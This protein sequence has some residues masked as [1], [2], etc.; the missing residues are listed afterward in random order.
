MTNPSHQPVLETHPMQPT[1]ILKGE[2]R[3]IE[4]VLSCLERIAD[5]CGEDRR[6]DG[7]SA[8]QALEFFQTFAD[9]CHHRK[10]EA[11]LFPA[12][13]AKGFSPRFGPTY[14]MRSEHDEGRR[15]IRA[16]A[17]AVE[18]ASLGDPEAVGQCLEHAR[19]YARLPRA[20]IAK[21]DRCLFPLADEVFS[22]A[23]QEALLA[24][25]DDVEDREMHVGTHE[26]YLRVADELAER[27][28]LSR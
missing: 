16:M 18:D 3:V 8:R 22:A 6:L 11:H 14:M 17:E 21:E 19:G 20:H 27:F 4:Q 5:D 13:E 26:K 24:V 2:H 7:F 1:D 25:F 23:D 9:G 12:L 10:E 15:H 28:H